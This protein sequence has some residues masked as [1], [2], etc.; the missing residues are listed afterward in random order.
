MTPADPGVKLPQ[1]HFHLCH[2]L[3][4]WPWPPHVTSL[5][6]VSFSSYTT[7]THVR[8][9]AAQCPVYML[10]F[11]SNGTRNKLKR[12]FFPLVIVRK[13]KVTGII[14]VTP[15]ALQDPTETLAEKQLF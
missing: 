1:L 10:T 7:S 9:Q 2:Q 3:T 14:N 15:W 13:F 6:S 5:T 11:V 4:T 8:A 12:L